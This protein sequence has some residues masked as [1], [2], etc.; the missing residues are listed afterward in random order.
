[1]KKNLTLTGMMGVGKSTIGKAVSKRLLMQFS[2]IDEIIENKLK[3]SISKIFEEKGEFFFRKF[4][5]EISLHELAKKNIVVSLGGGAFMSSKIRKKVISSGKSF[6]LDLDTKLLE[7]RLFKSKKRP[8]LK[9][10]NLGES[11]KKIYDERKA[12][13][14][15]AN[16]RIDCNKLSANLI[17][18]KIIKIYANDQ[19]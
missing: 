13:Y 6:W 8:L 1:M 19:T 15:N 10:K 3:M 2:D 17:S 7:K 9:N 16:Y 14:A 18:N 4:E 12:I 5:E 11:L